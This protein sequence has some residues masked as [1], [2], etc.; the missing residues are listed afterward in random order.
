MTGL[1]DKWVGKFASSPLLSGRIVL[2]LI[3]PKKEGLEGTIENQIKG[4]G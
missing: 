4:R 3:I 2:T 1:R